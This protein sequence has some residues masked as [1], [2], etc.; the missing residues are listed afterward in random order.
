MTNPSRRAMIGSTIG[1]G[2]VLACPVKAQTTPP[3]PRIEVLAH[4]GASALR[5]EHS[6]A[7]YARAIEDGADFI[8]PDLFLSKDGVLVSIH[9]ADLAKV[10]DVA[11]YPEFADRRRRIQ[12]GSRT[13]EGWFTVDFTFAELKTLRLKE[14]IPDIRPGNARYDGQ[15]QILSLDEIIDFAAAQSATRDRPVGIVPE[16][17]V[18][19][20]F[21]SIGMPV[22]DRFFEVISSHAW[23]KTAP[24][25]IQ[26]FEVE[27][28]RSL[29]GRFGTRDNLRFM[30]LIDNADQVPLDIAL[31]QGERT[32]GDMMT[33]DGL[34]AM[35]EYADIVSPGIRSLI[36]LQSDGRLGRP[37]PSIDWA[38][39]A[40]LQVSGYEFRPENQFIAADFRNGDGD[41]ARNPEGSIAEIHHYLAAGMDNF[42]TDDPGIG[43]QAADSF[44][45]SA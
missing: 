33:L 8:E 12:V 13:I 3:A 16:L 22:E 1:L 38:K 31:K 7:A 23:L 41:I 24:L 44:S 18:P 4:R 45:R 32:Y 39:A 26:C 21:A 17:K 27:T 35:A 15:F 37:S 29:R 28:L 42:F 19:S 5:P 30:Q 43:R 25:I 11:S 20:L 10:T 6:L 40:G 34:K 2:A 14:R 36:P 9:E